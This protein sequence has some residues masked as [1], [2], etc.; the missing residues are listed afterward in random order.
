[1]PK[2]FRSG[3]WIAWGL[4]FAVL[5][6]MVASTSLFA[7]T[8]L[9]RHERDVSRMVFNDNVQLLDEV[10]KSSGALDDSLSKVSETADPASSI[11]GRQARRNAPAA[12]SAAL[13]EP[14]RI[15]IKDRRR[16][17]PEVDLGLTL[18]TIPAG[19]P[20]NVFGGS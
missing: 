9:L 15:V 4:I 6:L 10:R 19:V 13:C 20:L 11:A 7:R 2:F 5:T 16:T 17:D 1:M 3:G 18:G 14:I 8:A 12:R